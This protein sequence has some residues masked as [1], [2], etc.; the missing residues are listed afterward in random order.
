MTDST[1]PRPPISCDEADALAGAWGLDALDG[2]EAAAVSEHLETC[3]LPHE[4]LRQAAGAGAVLAAALEKI[5]PSPQ[6]R[7]R[8]MASIGGE[9]ERAAS[10]APPEPRRMPPWAPRA[11]AG[12]AAAA[13]IILAVWNVSLQGELATREARLNRLAE[14]LAASGGQTITVLGQAG[15][16]VLVEG[17]GRT[18]LVADV[19]QP[20]AGMLYEMWLIGPDG[21]PIDVGTFSPEPGEAFVVVE[22]ERS[23]EGFDVFAVTL[24]QG[25]VDAPTGDPV[26][27]TST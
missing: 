16:G 22:L 13:V 27:V 7:E 15:R 18:L 1:A 4:E 20:A 3:D 21:E 26:L 25:R 5:E 23:F 9:P 17:E 12:L 10:P 24:E 14:T 11:L 6:L 2:D 8:V 19:Q